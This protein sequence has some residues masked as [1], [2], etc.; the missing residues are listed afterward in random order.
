MK[1]LRRLAIF[2]LMVMPPAFSS[3]RVMA[4]GE[5]VINS[6]EQ[7]LLLVGRSAVVRTDRAIQRV[8]LSTPEIADAMVTAPREMLVHGK[9]P[10]TISLFVWSDNGRITNYEVIVRRDLTALEGQIRRQ[11]PNEPIAVAVN[12]KDVVLSGI[13]SAKHVI[14]RAGQLAAGYVDKPENIVNMMR[15]TESP[16]TSQVMLRVRFAEVGRSAMQELGVSLFTGP[17]GAGDWLGRSTTQQYPAPTFDQDRGLVFSDFLNLFLFNTEEQLGIAVRALKGKGLFQSLAEPNLITQDGKEA[18]FLAGGEFPYPVVQGG[19][20]NQ[21]VTIVFK[22]FG[23]RLR[24]TPTITGG[25]YVHLKVEPEVSTLDFANGVTLEGFRV[26]ALATRRTQTEVEL[27]DGQTFAISGLLDRN[28]DETLRRVP[29]IGDI[30]ILGYLFR[31]SAYRKNTTELVVMIT[32][33][34]MQRDSPGVTP[35]LPGLSE[36]FLE[37]PTRTIPMPGPAFSGAAPNVP[38]GPARTVVSNAPA[39]APTSAP[40]SAPASQTAMA[41]KPAAAAAKPVASVSP[42]DSSANRRAA[43]R[44]KAEI[45]RLEREQAERDRKAA[46][47][48]A[49]RAAEEEKKQKREL[50]VS[51]KADAER[52][53][54]E[55]KLEEKRLEEQA[56][57]DH[58][59][60]VEQQE[61]AAKA[62]VVAD[63]LAKEQARRDAE[64]KRIENARLE[65]ERKI[66][67]KHQKAQDKLAREQASRN[68]ELEKLIT[69]YKRLTG[70]QP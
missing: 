23:V 8:S 54:R 37:Q 65:E 56:A 68:G 43:E 20:A 60:W 55:K 50:E 41:G 18:S 32:P 24:F 58:K 13:V 49:A 7:I 2:V 30:P 38:A 45:A 40:T 12:G 59:R 57:I 22:E 10:G 5:P 28:L 64:Q 61:Q 44:A 66:A 42:D 34:I 26:P 3:G 35:N 69:Q 52:E 16:M 27:R 67:E 15:Q 62:K 53:A 9:A 19:G 39:S 1:T 6:T 51:R 70:E 31:S 17:N 29:G 33:H 36:P 25:G 11:F 48:E 46:E 47:I 21:S 4:A 63:K 14:D